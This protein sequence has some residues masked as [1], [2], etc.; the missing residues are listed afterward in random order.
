MPKSAADTGLADYILP[1]EQMPA[2]LLAYIKRSSQ[3]KSAGA[4]DVLTAG[5]P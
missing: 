4:L 1:V 5:V 3:T 2:Q